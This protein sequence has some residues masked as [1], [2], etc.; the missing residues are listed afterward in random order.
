MFI[1]KTEYLI[2]PK[3]RIKGE[4]S[5]KIQ[6]SPLSDSVSQ[7]QN[8][9]NKEPLN[10]NLNDISFKGSFLYAQANKGNK[11]LKNELLDFLKKNLGHMGEDLYNHV[12]SSELPIARKMFQVNQQTGEIIFHKKSIPHLIKDGLILKN[13]PSDIYNG[14]IVLLGKIKPLKNWAE[15]KLSSQSMKQLRA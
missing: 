3:R 15:N 13:L 10:N 2:S 7:F 1:E 8:R 6:T 5:P 14:S 11:Y 4:M 12:A 9:L